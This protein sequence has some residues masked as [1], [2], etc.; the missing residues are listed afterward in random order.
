MA[1]V[2]TSIALTAPAAPVDA[3]VNDQFTFTGTPGFTGTGGVQRY[4]MKWEVDSG[5]GFVTIASSGTGL[6]TASTNPLV[7]SNSASANSITIDCSEVGSYTIRIVG[8][9]TSGGS[10]TVIS[11]TQTVEVTDAS[12]LVT[13]DVLALT[14][15]TFAPTVTATQNELV[16]PTT[17]ALSLSSFAP[18]ITTTANQLVTPTTATLTLSLFAPTVTGG[19]GITVTPSTASLTTSLFAPTVTAT[20]NQLITP[21]KLSLALSLFAPTVTATA[22]QTATPATATLL[23]STFA[24]TVTASGGEDN[25]TI[26]APIA[27][28]ENSISYPNI[29][30]SQFWRGRQY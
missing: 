15:A 26:D 23:L 30:R 25:D 13:P 18:T 7:N 20:A 9:P 6:T 17:A 29:P 11:S 27:S 16:T 14:T 8:A 19:S 28:L 1:K 22:N 10:Y 5:G 12:V 24:P 3:S 21:S 2:L 4:D